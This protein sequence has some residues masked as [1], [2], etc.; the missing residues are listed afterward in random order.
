MHSPAC[1]TCRAVHALLIDAEPFVVRR[2]VEALARG[3][4]FGVLVAMP[5]ELGAETDEEEADLVAARATGRYVGVMSIDKLI[6][7][8]PS[9]DLDPDEVTAIL[10]QLRGPPPAGQVHVV[11]TFQGC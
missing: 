2:G 4:G 1:P 11:C 5:D 10:R 6:Q 7:M 3:P 8:I 9:R